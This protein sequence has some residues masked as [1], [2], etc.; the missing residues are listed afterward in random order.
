MVGEDFV[1]DFREACLEFPELQLHVIEDKQYCYKLEGDFQIIDEEGFHWG[2]FHAS[3]Y[4]TDNYPKGFPILQ[5]HS[6]AFP[7]TD[8]WHIA[9]EDGLCCVC[10]PIEQAE[11]SLSGIKVLD[12]ITMYVFPF[13]A[14]QIYKSEYGSYKNGE[15]AHEFDGLWQALFEEFNVSSKEEV[16]MLL[17]KM[18]A[19]IGRNDPCFCGSERK[20]KKCHLNRIEIIEEVL[21]LLNI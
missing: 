14:N 16:K 9:P 19:K 7:W 5:D 1:R 13:Y 6:K 20:F 17:S 11:K 4:F 10:G 12:F 2:T 8:E 3:I 21:I 15:Y 18:D